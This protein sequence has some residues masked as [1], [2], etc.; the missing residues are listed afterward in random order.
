MTRIA[1]NRETGT[2]KL[3]DF[4]TSCSPYSDILQKRASSPKVQFQ[5][6]AVDSRFRGN[7]EL[8]ANECT[9]R[10]KCSRTRTSISVE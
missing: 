7:Y 10:Y 3:F 6:L 9:L 4:N 2:C 5:W 1:K 8:R